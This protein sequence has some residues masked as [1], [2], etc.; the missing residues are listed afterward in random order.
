M[1]MPGEHKGRQTF[2]K[3]SPAYK[4]K[5]IV[6]SGCRFPYSLLVNGIIFF[7]LIFFS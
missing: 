4:R 3:K 7:Y 2:G 5:S 1:Q 6:T